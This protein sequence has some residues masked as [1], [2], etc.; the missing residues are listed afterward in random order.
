MK[1][2][3][4]NI[5]DRRAEIYRVVKQEEKKSTI[6]RFFV[7]IIEFLAYLFM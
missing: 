7:P 5:A 4:Y 1:K 6:T 3:N 2:S